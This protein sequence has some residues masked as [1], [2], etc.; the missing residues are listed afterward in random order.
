LIDAKA[1]GETIAQSEW[2]KAGNLDPYEILDK[3][4]LTGKGKLNLKE[5]V[6]MTIFENVAVSSENECKN[7][8]RDTKK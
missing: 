7:C 5:F 1:I 2:S 8:F 6:Y 3:Y 4:D